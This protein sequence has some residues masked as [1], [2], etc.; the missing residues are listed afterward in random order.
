MFFTSN[1]QG[2]PTVT[3]FDGGSNPSFTL[4]GV[5]PGYHLYELVFD[6]STSTAS[7]FVEGIE[8]ISGWPGRNVSSGQGP[9]VF[10]GSG[11]DNDTGEGRYNLVTFSV[12]TAPNPAP[13]PE[14]S[15]L[16][17]LGSGLALVVGFGR[18]WRR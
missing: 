16:L 17:L 18:R 9:Y 5:G 1:A 3:L 14:P 11:Q 8:R 12:N 2:D 7:L 6:P 15:T 4:N 13:V 10:W